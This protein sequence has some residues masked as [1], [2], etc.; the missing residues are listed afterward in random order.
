MDTRLSIHGVS[1]EDL[2]IL[3]EAA[4]HFRPVLQ[5]TPVDL[6]ESDLLAIYRTAWA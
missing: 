2:P 1:E 4:T 3:A 6:S 5:N